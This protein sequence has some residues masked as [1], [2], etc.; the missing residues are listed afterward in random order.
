MCTMKT[1]MMLAASALALSLGGLIGGASTQ[2]NVEWAKSLNVE[3]AASTLNVEWAASTRNVE[4]AASNR[5]VEWA[6]STDNVEWA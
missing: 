4:W 6:A 3:W 2:G 5:N 1:K